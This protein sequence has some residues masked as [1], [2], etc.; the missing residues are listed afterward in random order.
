MIVTNLEHLH[1]QVALTASLQAAIDFLRQSRTQALVDGRVEV[2]G[3]QVY[4][5][6]QSYETYNGEP[7]FEAHRNYLDVQYVA[8]GEEVLGWAFIDRLVINVP[9]DEAKDVCFGCVPQSDI[10]LVRLSAGQCAVLYPTDAHAPKLAAS[11]PT[12]VKKIVVKVAI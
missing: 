12:P 2:H 4:A 11:M 3:D 10:T 1:E 6:I 7:K 8:E 9:Y 5:V